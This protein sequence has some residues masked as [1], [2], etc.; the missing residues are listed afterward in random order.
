MSGPAVLR[1]AAVADWRAA[2][3]A[4]QKLKKN[5]ESPRAHARAAKP[6]KRATL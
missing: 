6:Q 1:T 5:G 2:E 3:A 4:A